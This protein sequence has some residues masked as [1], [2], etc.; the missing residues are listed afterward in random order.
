MP[1]APDCVPGKITY[2][3]LVRSGGSTRTTPPGPTLA[4]RVPCGLATSTL[5]GNAAPDAG[6]SISSLIVRL[7]GQVRCSTGVESVELAIQGVP[8]P[9]NK[10]SGPYWS[11]ESQVELADTWKVDRPTCARLPTRR[12]SA[13]PGTATAAAVTV[14]D[15]AA[16]TWNVRASTWLACG[17]GAAAGEGASWRKE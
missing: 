6:L 11:S 7:P 13:A 16:G 4:S 1:A 8:L 14:N 10:L 9:L 2:S 17:P 5:V 12:S 3:W 15:W